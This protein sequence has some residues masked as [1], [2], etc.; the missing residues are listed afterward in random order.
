MKTKAVKKIVEFLLNRSLDI[1]DFQLNIGTNYDS[2]DS[3]A[4]NA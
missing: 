4:Q 3:K 1:F 2:D